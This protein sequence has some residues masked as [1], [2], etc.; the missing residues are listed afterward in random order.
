VN[1]FYQRMC[2]GCMTMTVDPG[3]SLCDDCAADALSDRLGS[4]TT[5]QHDAIAGLCIEQRLLTPLLRREMIAEAVP[6]WHY[7]G[8][9]CLSCRQAGDVLML[10]YQRRMMTPHERT[11]D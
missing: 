4:I 9:N 11:K 3:L 1:A 6:G 7:N 10:L 8:L 2:P 5:E